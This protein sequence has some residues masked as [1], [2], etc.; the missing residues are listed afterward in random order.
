MLF[1]ILKQFYVVFESIDIEGG[2]GTKWVN[3]AS[4]YFLKANNVLST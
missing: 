4:Y 2:V 1:S 3:Q